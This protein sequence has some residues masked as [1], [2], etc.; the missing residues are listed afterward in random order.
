M[1]YQIR[2]KTASIFGR[3]WGWEIKVKA[4]VDKVDFDKLTT[5]Y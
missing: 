4:I 1:N 2:S 5:K 3:S